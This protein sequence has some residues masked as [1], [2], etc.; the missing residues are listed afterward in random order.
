MA[1]NQTVF[2][3]NRVNF[4]GSLSNSGHQN[5]GG[6]GYEKHFGVGVCVS[7]FPKLG[8]RGMDF[9]VKRGSRELIFLRVTALRT[10]FPA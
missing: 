9:V 4:Q 8:A 6:G 10:D 2:G 5:P 1:K 3:Q 7:S